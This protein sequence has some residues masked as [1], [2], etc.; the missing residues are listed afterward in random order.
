MRF[1]AVALVFFGTAA[2]Y[3]QSPEVPHKM[4]F[5]NMT[6]T[7]RDDARREIQKD[8]DGMTKH[9][10]YFNVTA[11]RARLYFPLVS[12]IFAEEGLPDDFKYL[13]LQESS[14]VADAVSVSNAVGFWQFKDFTALSMGL[15]VDKE[16]DERMN[17]ASATRG[18][19]NYLKKN[20]EQFDNWILALQAYQMGAGGL[21]R[22]VGDRFNGKRHLEIT[23][24][25]Y[26]YIKKFIAH[27]VAFEK[28]INIES[29]IKAVFIKTN[30][31]KTM[32][33]L[34]QELSVDE[35]LL[36][37]YNKWALKGVV[38]DD[39]TYVVVV[40]SSS[41]EGSFQVLAMSSKKASK[42]SPIVSKPKP[43]LAT[44][45][46]MIN[47]VLAIKPLPGESV[48]T[49]S[50]RAGISLSKFLNYN[51]I[52]IDYPISEA[53]YYFLG[54]KKNQAAQLYHKVKLGDDLWSISQQ[55]GVKGRKLRKWN[56]E[57]IGN[58]LVVGSVIWLSAD[59]SNQQNLQEK[60]L[61]DKEV[62]SLADET[63]NWDVKPVVETVIPIEA[64]QIIAR[65]DSS[66][67]ISS[68][69]EV[70]LDSS[71]MHSVATGDTF[72][73]IAKLYN[74]SVVDLMEWN[75]LTAQSKLFS[76]QKLKL[77]ATKNAQK[78]HLKDSVDSKNTNEI[79]VFHLVKESDTLYG[80]ARQYGVTIRDLMS[81][82]DKKEL[83]IK[84]GEKLR[85]LK[86]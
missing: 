15:R 13:C 41:I 72:Y 66:T 55:Y 76:N 45:T 62:I 52:E 54:K 57:V 50:A 14:L 39:K 63:F 74:V 69:L 64:K 75:G 35:Q 65:S 34:A 47:G 73:G 29:S 8:V 71:F 25:T 40:P 1:F 43:P 22:S 44:S 33:E 18:A 10:R 6:L 19:A 48:A 83:T 81:W 79:E 11:E 3:A 37:Q 30:Q 67:L 56:K 38:P 21:R 2:L 17:I 42:A 26:W 53:T 27:R 80:I 5:A 85:I 86:K 24:E 84:Q 77:F 78:V 20:N 31:R 4:H 61:S 32:S 46:K 28:A 82:N 16:I 23:S 12:K 70:A 60:Q 9:A 36:K 51:E 58:K 59:R 68:S 7:I 49:L